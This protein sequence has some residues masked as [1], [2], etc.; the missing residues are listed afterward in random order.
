MT[1]RGT[2]VR[3]PA[4]RPSFED[5]NGLKMEASRLVREIQKHRPDFDRTDPD[6]DRLRNARLFKHEVGDEDDG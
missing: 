3:A 2:P 5:I 4:K 6:N 1:T